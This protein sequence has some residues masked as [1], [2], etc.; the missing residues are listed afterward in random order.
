MSISVEHA[1]LK[2][3]TVMDV[4]E[5]QLA[6]VYAKAFLGATSSTAGQGLVDELSVDRDDVLNRFPKF[7]QTLR[8]S[9]VSP[10]Q[11]EELLDRVFGGKVSPECST[12]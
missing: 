2:H 12:S 4:T 10:E 5:E 9:L 11:K 3:D 7:D 1:K 6:R 8:S